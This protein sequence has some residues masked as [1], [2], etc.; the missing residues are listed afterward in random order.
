MFDPDAQ[1][2]WLTLFPPGNTD[3]AVRDESKFRLAWVERE[4]GLSKPMVP[5]PATPMPGASGVTPP[6]IEMAWYNTELGNVFIQTFTRVSSEGK[7][8]FAVYS[9]WDSQKLVDG[10]AL[11]KGAFLRWHPVSGAALPGRPNFQ[12]TGSEWGSGMLAKLHQKAVY[13]AANTTESLDKTTRQALPSLVGTWSGESAFRVRMYRNAGTLDQSVSSTNSGRTDGQATLRIRP[14]GTYTM[15]SDSTFSACHVVRDHDGTLVLYGDPQHRNV[16]LE[17]E[18]FIERVEQLNPSAPCKAGT[19]V[20]APVIQFE[21][22]RIATT[23][24][25]QLNL[26]RLEHEAGDSPNTT[27]QM[28]L[29][30]QAEK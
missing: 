14:D 19:T 17:A 5:F 7:V 27:H 11:A 12:N 16:R 22:E 3:R 9:A 1:K 2:T 25:P 10:A 24:G 23:A 21:M 6:I 26:T 8:F 4:L 28:Q 30:L 29:V 18:H 20:K 13:A 15:H